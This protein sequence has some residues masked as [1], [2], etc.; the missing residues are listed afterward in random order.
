MCALELSD[1]DDDSSIL[2]RL[3]DDVSKYCLALVPHSDLPAMASVCKRW[4]CFIQADKEN[5][6]VL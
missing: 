2:P 4:R 5:W 3:P 1:E 6:L